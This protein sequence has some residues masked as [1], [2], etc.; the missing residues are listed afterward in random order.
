MKIP[1]LKLPQRIA[2]ALPPVLQWVPVNMALVR[3]PEIRER[4]DEP[5]GDV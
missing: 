1:Q 5:L 3:P 2:D 4:T